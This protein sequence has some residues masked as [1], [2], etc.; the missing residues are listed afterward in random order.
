MTTSTR[1]LT[2]RGVLQSSIAG[3]FALCIPEALQAA[4]HRHLAE[5]AEG[6]ASAAGRLEMIKDEFKLSR[7]YTLD[8][9]EALPEEKYGFRPVP[10]VRSFGQQM[11]H[12]AE[13]IP[14]MYERFVEQSKSPIHQFSEAGK[15]EVKSKADVIRK[16]N[17]SYDYIEKSLASLTEANLAE[18]TKFFR[19]DTTKERVLHTILDHTTHHRGQSVTYLRLNGIKPPDYRA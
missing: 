17:E 8:C 9:A 19:R 1:S 14:G 5:K 15:E 3:A 16:L 12:I 6:G 11:T 4:T 13:S 10:E 7:S 2:R 18:P